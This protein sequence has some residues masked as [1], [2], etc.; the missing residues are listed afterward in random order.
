MG[1]E[2]VGTSLNWNKYAL[3][4]S[5]I[6]VFVGSHGFIIWH[7]FIYRLVRR[8]EAKFACKEN[9]PPVSKCFSRLVEEER[10]TPMKKPISVE[11]PE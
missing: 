9:C 10:A 6:I 2:G 5:T 11:K 1:F 3:F 8:A 7:V 4:R